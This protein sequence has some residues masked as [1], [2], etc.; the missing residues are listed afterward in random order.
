MWGACLLVRSQHAE[1]LARKNGYLVQLLHQNE[2]RNTKLVRCVNPCSAKLACLPNSCSKNNL[3]NHLNFGL[4][5]EQMETLA[6][7]ASNAQ[8]AYGGA[9]TKLNVF[10]T[11][12]FKTQ[13]RLIQV[14]ANGGGGGLHAGSRR[15]VQRGGAVEVWQNEPG[16]GRGKDGVMAARGPETPTKTGVDDVNPLLPRMSRMQIAGSS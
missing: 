8:E 7:T 14:E 6:Q 3:L 16:G 13:Q 12:L 5:V 9:M 10:E 4:Q 1:N 11:E 2:E 15:V